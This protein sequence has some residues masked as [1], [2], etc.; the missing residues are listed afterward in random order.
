MELKGNVEYIV[1]HVLF[2]PVNVSRAT[3]IYL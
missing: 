1:G 3:E 2:E